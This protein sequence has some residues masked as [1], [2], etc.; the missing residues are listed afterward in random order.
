MQVSSDQI[1]RTGAK[2]FAPVLLQAP[3][4][5]AQAQPHGMFL[6]NSAKAL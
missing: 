1:K 6:Y 2:G 3:V 5:K 4:T